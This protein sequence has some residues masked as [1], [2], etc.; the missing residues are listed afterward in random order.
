MSSE[1]LTT[2]IPALCDTTPRKPVPTK[3]HGVM[4]Q[5]KYLSSLH[6]NLRDLTFTISH[7]RFWKINIP[8]HFRCDN[9]DDAVALSKYEYI[10]TNMYV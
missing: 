5:N 9:S 2:N 6:W 8:L 7:N 1:A 3:L 10:T 4:S